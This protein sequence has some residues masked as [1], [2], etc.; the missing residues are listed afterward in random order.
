M[1]ANRQC[2]RSARSAEAGH[3]VRWCLKEAQNKTRTHTQPNQRA[4]RTYSTLR[5][6]NGAPG[7]EGTCV[8]GGKKLLVFQNA[9]KLGGPDDDVLVGA[10]GSKPLAIL[11]ERQA[12]HRVF[13]A[14]Q[15]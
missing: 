5:V 13:V 9:F 1:A 6:C 11:L 7:G 3:E 12:K 14:T 2:I 4:A 8:Q 10:A 15:R